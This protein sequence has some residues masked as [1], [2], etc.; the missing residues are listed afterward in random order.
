VTALGAIVR[1]VPVL[2]AGF[3]LN[4]GGLFVEM[5]AA[6]RAG[7]YHLPHTVAYNGLDIPFAYPPLGFVLGAAWADITGMSLIDTAR[8]LPLT[9]SIASVPLAYAIYRPLLGTFARAL[10]ATTGF[11]LM[12]RSYNW[13]VAGGGVTRS[14]GLLLA[15]ATVAACIQLYRRPRPGWWPVLTGLAAGLCALSHPQAAVFVGVSMVVLLPFGHIGKQAS[16]IRL[17]LTVLVAAVTVSPWLVTVIAEHGLPTLLGAAQTGGNI[18]DSLVFFITFRFSDGFLEFLGI[19]GAFGLFVCLVNRQWLLPLWTTVI[20][21]V[22]ARA[23]LTYATVPVAGA[24]AYAVL[25]AFRWLRVQEPLSALGWFRPLRAAALVVILLVGGVVD[26]LASRYDPESPLVPLSADARAAMEWASAN[27]AEDATFLVAAGEPWHLD[28]VSEWF[29]VI[30]DRRSLA[31][32]QGWEWL[33]PGK[34]GEQERRNQWL[35][36]CAALTDTDCAAEWSRVIEPVDYVLVTEGVRAASLGHPCCLQ[37]VERLI[38][39]GGT[40]AFSQGDVRIVRIASP[41]VASP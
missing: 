40:I 9:L 25:D 20:F 37:L 23:G 33:G 27:T 17:S 39:A 18:A 16:A 28:A 3:P 26:S 30:A 29:P 13:E 7:G 34:F 8:F 10:A 5:M 6:L 41:E 1:A 4:D 36:N 11:A 24:I 21:M 14:L 19:I 32:V 38:E 12:A 2:V 22:G 35:L 31:T 15:L